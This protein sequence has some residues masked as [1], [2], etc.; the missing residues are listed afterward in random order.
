MLKIESLIYLKKKTASGEAGLDR[1][2]S[3]D[4]PEDAPIKLPSTPP[5]VSL[6]TI[7]G[8]INYLS[9]PEGEDIESFA[10]NRPNSEAQEYIAMLETNL[11]ACLPW[12]HQLLFSTEDLSKAPARGI[13]EIARKTVSTNQAIV[14]R[15]IL[16]AVVWAMGNAIDDGL[17]TMPSDDKWI[18]HIGFT[19]PAQFTLDAGQE[20]AADIAD[21]KMGLKTRDDITTKYG[22]R[23]TEV[24]EQ[25]TQ[26]TVD[27]WSSCV[28]AK[29]ILVKKYPEDLKDL[30]VTQI[31]NDIQLLTANPIPEP[32]ANTEQPA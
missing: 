9:A 5:L 15:F 19:K 21:Y 1:V 13:T 4:P 2:T 28:D 11:L 6:E 27:L 12:P 29:N 30:T 8:G 7:T 26:E 24:L 20:R 25:K 31:H 32:P 22:K 10:S 23:G 14:E 3:F 16:P 18:N 17:L